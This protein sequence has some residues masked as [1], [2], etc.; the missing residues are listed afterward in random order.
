[1]KVDSWLKITPEDGYD[2]E[3]LK[4]KLTV[5][6]PEY[7]TRKKM[8]FK[9][10]ELQVQGKCPN[11]G[12]EVHETYQK[13]KDIPK[14]CKRCLS[15]VKYLI[16]EVEMRRKDP[17]YKEVGNELWVPRALVHNYQGNNKLEDNT[18]MGDREVDFKSKIQ[19]GP[20]EH[21][22]MDQNHFVDELTKSLQ[23]GY[24]AIGQSLAGSGKTVMALEVISRLK[25]PTAVL[26]H[27]EFLMNQWAERVMDFYNIKKEDVGFVQQDVCEYSNKKIV[28]IMIQSLLAREYPKS[29]FDYFG[30]ICID[31]VHRVAATEFRKS[32]VL[33]PARYRFGV[34]ATPR[35]Q[36]NL[37]NVFFW[38]VGDIAVVGEQQG[39]K[40][41]VKVVKTNVTPTT[42]ERNRFYDF[43]GKQNLN[44]VT[45]YLINSSQRNKLIVSLLVKALK[46]NRKV[47]LLSGRLAHLEN[48]KNMLELQMIK[49]GI[50]HTTGYYI[51]GMKEE[52]R[53]ISATRQ[54]IFGTF[55]MAQE[56]LDIQDL[57]SLFLT[58]PKSDI[59]QSTGRILRL[60]EGKKKPIVIDF[61][62]E[63]EICIAMLKKRVNMYKDL[64]Y[65]K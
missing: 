11:C 50:R 13:R 5:N 48:L 12:K 7:L 64:G 56:A 6:N 32:I 62:D 36:D 10:T 27:K 38:H 45:D 16:D 15:P 24:G 49:E 34:T 51:G 18:T 55:A 57:D 52:E 47:L 17:L 44:K 42:M 35:R 53:T 28:I 33:F 22:A 26:V 46:A 39:L 1:M 30:T 37:E 29:L 65:M 58:T 19:L 3:L 63:I 61:S 14:E 25:R 20:N 59:E 8:G 21:T 9:T 43:R 23:N 4:P 54:C 2:Y 60:M 41:E 40:P 31:E